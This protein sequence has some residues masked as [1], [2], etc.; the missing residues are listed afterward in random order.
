MPYTVTTPQNEQEFVELLNGLLVGSK[1]DGASEE[2]TDEQIAKHLLEADN[3]GA[4][5]ELTA[6]HIVS[7]NFTLAHCAVELS[8]GSGRSIREFFTGT[9]ADGWNHSSKGVLVNSN[10]PYGCKFVAIDGFSIPGIPI[11]KFMI[12]F[13]YDP[14]DHK[15]AVYVGKSTGSLSFNKGHGIFSGD[16][17]Q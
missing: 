8:K 6:T 14:K 12:I 10:Q 5:A 3:D 17:S 4:D 13:F 15:Y 1:I 7:A 9:S 2:L 11:L 16:F